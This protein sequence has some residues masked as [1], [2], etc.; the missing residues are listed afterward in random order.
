MEECAPKF[1]VFKEQK[2]DVVVDVVIVEV[3]W[4]QNRNQVDVKRKQ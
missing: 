4:R 3:V 1:F 2:E